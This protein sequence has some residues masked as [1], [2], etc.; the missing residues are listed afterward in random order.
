VIVAP[1]G[2]AGVTSPTTPRTEPPAV[3]DVGLMPNASSDGIAGTSGST[4]RTAPCSPLS[5]LPYDAWIIP[6]WLKFA[7]LV[8]TV[9]DALRLPAGTVT[10]CVP[11][12]LPVTWTDA[13]PA[14]AGPVSVTVPVADVPPTT[15]G[16]VNVTVERLG[17]GA[18]D[19]AG[20][21]VSR[22]CGA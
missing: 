4:R 21:I 8:V 19:P 7:S 17:A 1:P 11:L 16:D 18:V 6:H 12:L 15:A 9:N 2:G 20:L 10:C 3:V 14:G 5:L 22:A 13:P